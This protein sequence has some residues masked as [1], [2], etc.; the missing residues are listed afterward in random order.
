MI[1]TSIPRAS[2]RDDAL[3]LWEVI[4]NFV[5]EV[6]SIY[7]K[8]DGDVKG[9]DELKA[10]VQDIHQN[11]FP[12]RPGDVDHE[13]PASVKTRD[14]L[15]HLITCVLFNCSCQHAAVSSNMFEVCAFIPNTP[16]LMRQPPP[17]QKGTATLEL[18]MNTLPDKSQAKQHVG[19]ISRLSSSP[20]DKVSLMLCEP[21][22]SVHLIS[23]Y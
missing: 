17:T 21:Y 5:H 18:I 11:G 4:S 3:L 15:A 13:F 23:Y 8:S 20:R 12:E 10:W 19:A 1:D 16:P 22:F 9:D 14:Q 6:L 2:D 7:Y